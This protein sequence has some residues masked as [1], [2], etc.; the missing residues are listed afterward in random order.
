[1]ILFDIVALLEAPEPVEED[2]KDSVLGFWTSK[3]FTCSLALWCF[4]FRIV[5]GCFLV[6]PKAQ[7]PSSTWFLQF[8]PFDFGDFA[9]WYAGNRIPRSSH[10]RKSHHLKYTKETSLDTWE[11]KGA[12]WGT[13]FIKL[14]MLFDSRF[15][16][17]VATTCNDL[18][19]NSG[20]PWWFYILGA[21]YE[22]RPAQL[23]SFCRNSDL[24]SEKK[25]EDRFQLVPIC[26]NQGSPFP[27]MVMEWCKVDLKPL[28]FGAQDFFEFEV[29][30]R[31]RPLSIWY[32]L[33]FY[34]LL[35]RFCVVCSV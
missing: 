23:W 32:V 35:F 8:L 27:C 22:E 9:K 14:T 34:I 11:D 17:D 12:K 1:M 31:S 16:F 30:K 20:L 28:R 24:L 21:V 19:F 15:C 10:T 3:H 7:I 2:V 25:H 4:H 13:L 29:W 18:F 6:G 26:S 33:I 5:S